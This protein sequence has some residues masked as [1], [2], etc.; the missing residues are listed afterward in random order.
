M[1]AP[2][3][4]LRPSAAAVWVLCAGHLKLSEGQEGFYADDEDTTVREEGIGAH[5]VAH[6]TAQGRPPSIDTVTPNGV[7]VDDEMVEAVALYLGAIRAWP[8]PALFEHPVRCVLVHE[9]CGGTTDA[10]AYDPV[11]R[12]VY[13][14]DFKYGYRWVDAVRNW[15][16]ICYLAGVLNAYGLRL[17]DVTV[18]FMIVQ[19]RAYGSE[20]VRTWRVM[21]VDLLPQIAQL[22]CAALA[23]LGEEPLCTVNDGCGSCAGRHRCKTLR[24]GGAKATDEQH[25]ATP[26]DLPFAAAE[27]ELRRLQWAERVVQARITGLEQQ[28]L[29]GMRRGQISRHYGMQ[30]KAG[31]L[32]WKEGAAPIVEN[33]AKLYGV[34]IN[35]SQTLITPTQAKEKLP[36]DVV[37]MY[38]H[39]PTGSMKLVP[40]DGHL[41]AAI[42][43]KK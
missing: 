38:S 2:N 39:R 30:Q 29:H 15:Q 12:T 27:D 5:W 14:A 26:H 6:E 24:Q 36:D 37:A 25:L 18:V 17:E 9:E 28:V 42:F 22:Q 3:Y 1:L 34:N 41:M 20:A 43:G 7:V 40:A 19:P 35:K 23:A 31:R 16:L 11:T 8:V 33:V 32:V 4:R 10:C 13:V 21:G